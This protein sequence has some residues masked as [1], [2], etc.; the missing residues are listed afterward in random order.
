MKERWKRSSSDGERKKKEKKETMAGWG[1][2]GPILGSQMN[3]I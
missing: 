2:K 1:F 3:I